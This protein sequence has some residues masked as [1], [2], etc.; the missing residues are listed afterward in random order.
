M[1]KIVV[2]T[3]IE[4][5]NDIIFVLKITNYDDNFSDCLSVARV[6]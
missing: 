3:D 1:N 5:L 2:I 4:D 6:E